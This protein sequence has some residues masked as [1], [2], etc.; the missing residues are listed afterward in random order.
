[1][2]SNKV[3]LIIF[4]AKSIFISK[5]WSHP[6][7]TSLY[8]FPNLNIASQT[9][10][11]RILRARLPHRILRRLHPIHF[12]RIP[13]VKRGKQELDLQRRKRFAETEARPV[14]KGDKGG[15]EGAKLGGRRGQPALGVEGCGRGEDGGR[16][17]EGEGGCRDDRLLASA[18]ITHED[19]YDTHTPSGK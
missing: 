2:G 10:R 8:Q 12:R 19:I 13:R 1:M 3:Y 15:L 6:Q 14:A 5:R 4:I 16:V 18:H 9:P 11:N 17:M 7:F